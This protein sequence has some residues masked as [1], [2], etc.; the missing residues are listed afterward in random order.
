MPQLFLVPVKASSKIL[1]L[2]QVNMLRKP[3]EASCVCELGV[4]G[5]PGAS[6]P[7]GSQG[8]GIPGLTRV[9]SMPTQGRVPDCA[10]LPKPC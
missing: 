4:P 1:K 7:L 5:K 6:G 9:P 3:P 10:R 8:S 2:L